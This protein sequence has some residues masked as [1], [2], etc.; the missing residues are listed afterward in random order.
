MKDL[1]RVLSAVPLLETAPP[2]GVDMEVA[3]TYRFLKVPS[4]IGESIEFC[5]V[6]AASP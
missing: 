6:G 1:R 2:T 4:K 5:L 3:L